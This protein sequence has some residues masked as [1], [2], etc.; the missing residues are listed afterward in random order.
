MDGL[1]HLKPGR[2][3]WSSEARLCVSVSLIHKLLHVTLVYLAAKFCALT[4]MLRILSHCRF[5]A[6]C[7]SGISIGA[8]V[9]R[10]AVSITRSLLVT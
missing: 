9:L 3:L 2:P 4:P 1:P 10:F 5:E 6:V 7:T 8:P